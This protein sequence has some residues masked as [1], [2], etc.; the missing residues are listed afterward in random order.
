[1]LVVAGWGWVVSVCQNARL[2]IEQVLGGVSLQT[3]ETTYHAALILLCI[4]LAAHLFHFIASETPG[5]TWRPW[6]VANCVLN[7]VYVV[8]GMLPCNVF[9][10]SSRLSL[11]R[12]L[13]ESF[14]APFAPVTFWHVIVA[15]YLTSLAKAFS[16]LQLTMCISSKIFSETSI[17]EG[18]VRSTELWHA[19]FDVCANHPANAICLALPFWMRLMQCLKVYSQTHESKNL[20][21]ALKYSTAFPLVYAGYL[22]KHEPSPIHT[23]WFVIAAI[24]QSTYC[25]IWDVH[26]DWGLFRQ[27]NL[28]GKSPEERGTSF[29]GSKPA[30]CRLREPLLVTRSATAHVAL[31]IGDLLLRFVWALSVFGGVPSRGLGMFFFE[32]VEIVRRT[33]WAI[34]RIEWEVVSKLIYPAGTYESVG[35]HSLDPRDSENVDEEDEY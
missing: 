9:F 12:A 13:Y 2:E 4:L 10:G 35:L 6:L 32:C 18:Y 34:F 27:A 15:D 31:C 7:L 16:D 23:Q 26:M 30:V 29:C 3:P 11:L 28:G 20:W 24:V 1:M 33:V 5:V 25:F 22:K 19:S 14:I 17:S 21:N 8:I